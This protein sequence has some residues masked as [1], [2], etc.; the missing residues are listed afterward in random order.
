[1][2]TL[3]PADHQSFVRETVWKAVKLSKINVPESMFQDLVQ[4]GWTGLLQAAERFDADKHTRLTTYAY[5]WIVGRVV[6]YLRKEWVQYQTDEEFDIFDL[7]C[8]S[9]HE[10]QVDTEL[11]FSV[12]HQVV[13]DLNLTHVE[14]RYVQ[15]ASIK[16][17]AEEAE[18]TRQSM[19]ERVSKELEKVK[20]RVD[21]GD[22][23]DNISMSSTAN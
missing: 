17:M 7:G 6:R 10:R 22:V 5:P 11:D 8:D 15:G 20:K 21:S 12:V 1:M 19:H 23:K 14:Q 9:E 4:E 13:L 3:I 18:I 16:S 2:N